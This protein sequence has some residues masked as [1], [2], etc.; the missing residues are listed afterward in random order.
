[1]EDDAVLTGPERARRDLA[2]AASALLLWGL[3][4]GV[5]ALLL[6]GGALAEALWTVTLPAQERA[7]PTLGWWAAAVPLGSLALQVAFTALT[8]GLLWRVLHEP[9][10]RWMSLS[11]LAVAELILVPMALVT[12]LI[13]SAPSLLGDKP[14]RRSEEPGGSERALLY[15]R[16]ASPCGWDL[17]QADVL[18]PTAR[19][20]AT[21]DCDCAGSYPPATIGWSRGVAVLEDPH[22]QPYACAPP[23]ATTCQAG[24]SPVTWAL[25]AWAALLARRRR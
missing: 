4:V 8:A 17:Y 11:L 20:V 16:A 19:Q 24:P 14:V 10:W 21:V 25:M 1:M 13:A 18:D 6:G 12:A 9:L 5:P 15:E 7:V 22:G 23:P 2:L 3:L